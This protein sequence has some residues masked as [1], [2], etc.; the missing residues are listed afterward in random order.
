MLHNQAPPLFIIPQEYEY[1]KCLIIHIV[2]LPRTL[3]HFHFVTSER[4]TTAV[5]VFYISCSLKLERAFIFKKLCVNPNR[6]S[7]L[8][9]YTFLTFT[10][11]RL[12]PIFYE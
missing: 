2:F 9:T 6:L 10:I 8:S 1:R 11:S 3:I 12:K 5:E 4:S 7:W